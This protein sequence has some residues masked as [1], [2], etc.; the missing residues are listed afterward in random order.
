MYKYI[1]FCSTR[2]NVFIYIWI[3][4]FLNKIKLNW[5]S[6][7]FAIVFKWLADCWIFEKFYK[8]LIDVNLITF[9]YLIFI[10][11]FQ[12][13]WNKMCWL[14][15]RNIPKWFGQAS[16]KQSFPSE[17][18]YLY[19]LSETAFNGGGTLCHGWK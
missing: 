4:Y 10:P 13:I 7:N 9:I 15:T 6:L 2:F 19:N 8:T 1:A 14:Y 12:T 16:E 18:F 3:K 11:I 17:M 5:D